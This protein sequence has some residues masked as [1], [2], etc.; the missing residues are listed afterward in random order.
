MPRNK[1]RTYEDKIARLEQR[2]AD[3]EESRWRKADPEAQAR[4]NQFQEKADHFLQQAQE[5]EAAGNSSKAAK[6]REQAEQ[7]QEFANVAAKAVDEQ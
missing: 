2:V 1:V 3:A 6:L 7:W 5:A 4:V